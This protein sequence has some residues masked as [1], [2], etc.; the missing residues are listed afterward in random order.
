MKDITDSMCPDMK[1]TPG[2]FM[3]V[4][5]KAH[6]KYGKSGLVIESVGQGP[7]K[8]HR[9]LMCEDILTGTCRV[10]VFRI[11][12]LERNN[13]LIPLAMQDAIML[14]LRQEAEWRFSQSGYYRENDPGGHCPHCQLFLP[15]KIIHG[16]K[17]GTEKCPRCQE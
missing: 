11:E 12:N 4:T 1:L 10:Y 7:V 17:A 14:A 9:L 8:R 3:R 15:E 5:D 13:D 16:I 2:L 6:R